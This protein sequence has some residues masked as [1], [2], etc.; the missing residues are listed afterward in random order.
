MDR[1]FKSK[2][3]WWYHLILLVMATSTVAAFVGG[4]SPVTMIVLLLFT[5]ECIHMLLSTWYKITADGYLIAHCSIFPE[6]KIS[7]S[8]I[9]A[10]EV[11]GLFFIRSLNRMAMPEPVWFSWENC[12]LIIST[13]PVKLGVGLLY[14]FANR[15][16]KSSAIRAIML[17]SFLDIG[18]TTT[19]VVS[20]A[21]SSRVN[22][23]VDA[24]FGIVVSVFIIVVAIKMVVDN[25]K[26]IVV[27]DGA[28][29]ERKAIASACEEHGVNVKKVVLH[30]YGFGTKVG[31]VFIS[32]DG[33]DL[34]VVL[35][36]EVA[37]ACGADVTFIRVTDSDEQVEN[38]ENEV[39]NADKTDATQ[40]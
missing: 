33:E 27:G 10:V 29:D 13:L 5:L 28:Q 23:A 38:G 6:K 16:I 19:S 39:R 9:S 7:I 26:A 32:C 24:I 20:F 25:V 2:V 11:G 18:V 3:G 35:H 22:Y 17:D 21:V 14:Y 34:P 8:E 4:K 36:D 12:V 40:N 31:D 1:V 30:D 37:E 15:K